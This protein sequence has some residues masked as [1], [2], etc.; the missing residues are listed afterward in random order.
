[1]KYLLQFASIRFT[2]LASIHLCAGIQH[3]HAHAAWKRTT[4][5]A[6]LT[7]TCSIN[8]HMQRGHGHGHGHAAWTWAC[9]INMDMQRGHGHGHAA[10]M[11]M[12]MQ[13]GHGQLDMQHRHDM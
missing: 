7:W 9:S 11:D 1:M 4:G 6:A 2:I 13:H 10:W 5:H 12:D 3:S 8:M